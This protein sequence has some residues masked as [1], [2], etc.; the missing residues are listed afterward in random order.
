MSLFST[1]STASSGL[2]MA[3]TKL[4][5]IG[6]NIANINTIGFKGARAQVADLVA[7]TRWVSAVRLRSVPV[8]RQD[9]VTQLFG[10]GSITESANAL[11]LAISGN[12]FFML[13]DPAEQGALYTR[14]WPVLHGR[15][16]VHCLR[17]RS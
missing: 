8:V 14:D 5:V 9:T 7:A 15:G 13:K 11:D 16:R 3:G 6:D 10:Q 2:S 1:L 4:A 12:G 17:E